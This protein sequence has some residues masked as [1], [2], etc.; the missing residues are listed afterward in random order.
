VEKC[1]LGHD[2]LQ[3]RAVRSVDVDLVPVAEA[4]VDDACDVAPSTN[5]I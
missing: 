1:A 2:R 5:S 4:E 3:E